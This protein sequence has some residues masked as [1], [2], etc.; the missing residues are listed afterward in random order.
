ME[1]KSIAHYVPLM[2]VLKRKT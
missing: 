1:H 2:E